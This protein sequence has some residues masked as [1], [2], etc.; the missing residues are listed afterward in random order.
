MSV[1]FFSLFLFKFH[2]SRAKI[3][4]QMNGGGGVPKAAAISTWAVPLGSETSKIRGNARDL[5]TWPIQKARE[6]KSR[7]I[8]KVSEEAYAI[9]QLII[10]LK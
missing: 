7:N 4:A 6:K 3:K 10:S 2:F 1:G 5:L 9:T 8:L